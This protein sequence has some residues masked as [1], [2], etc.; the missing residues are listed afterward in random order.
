LFYFV[1]EWKAKKAA[2]TRSNL[3]DA[4]MLEPALDCSDAV[5]QRDVLPAQLPENF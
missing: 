4:R 1:A 2:W 5:S 3:K